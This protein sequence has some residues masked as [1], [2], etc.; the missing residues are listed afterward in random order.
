MPRFIAFHPALFLILS[1][2]RISRRGKLFPAKRYS[3]AVPYVNYA[4]EFAIDPVDPRD[5]HAII[6]VSCCAG[7]RLLELG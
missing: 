6:G 2:K 7:P 4:A 3:L 5:Q 1:G